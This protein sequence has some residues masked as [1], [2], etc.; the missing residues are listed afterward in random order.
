MGL[1]SPAH[2][3]ETIS[4]AYTNLHLFDLRV[5]SYK[6][7]VPA[8]WGRSLQSTLDRAVMVDAMDWVAR[9]WG[10]VGTAKPPL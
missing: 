9:G 7:P 3:V 1:G 6:Y 8:I 4:V 2:D 5:D 10:S